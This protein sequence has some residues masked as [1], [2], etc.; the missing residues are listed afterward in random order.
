MSNMKKVF[1]DITETL[2]E[3]NNCGRKVKT[4]DYTKC[5]KQLDE[6]HKVIL[7]QRETAKAPRLTHGPYRIWSMS[8]AMSCLYRHHRMVM[9]L[10]GD[11][12]HYGSMD[13]A[14]FVS[15]MTS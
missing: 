8:S 10:R 4:Y 9:E 12:E 15:A 6:M 13:Y 14:Y 1:F 2:K 3:G 7:C 11:P 5:W